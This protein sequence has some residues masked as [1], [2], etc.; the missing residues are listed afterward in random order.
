VGLAKIAGPRL[1]LTW[2]QKQ[3]SFDSSRLTKLPALHLK[4]GHIF[5]DYSQGVS[6][7]EIAKRL[8]RE[9]VL[10]PSGASWGP[11]TINGN[12]ERGTGI[13][14]VGELPGEGEKLF[15]RD[16]VLLLILK[17]VE[18]RH[19]LGSAVWPSIH[20]PEVRVRMLVA[21]SLL[22]TLYSGMRATRVLER[23]CPTLRC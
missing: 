18:P 19:E 7:R 22:A 23:R 16:W 9:G 15:P 21:H 11:S 4:R 5:R 20:D 1:R 8:N 12:R 13:L 10:G 3:S 6:P 2:Q 17:I 14:V